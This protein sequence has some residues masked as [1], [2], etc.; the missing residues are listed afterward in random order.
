MPPID[1]ERVRDRRDELGLRNGQ[2]ASELDL[3]TPSVENIMCGNA[4][5]SMRVVHGL[6]RL[7]GLTVAVI[8]GGA[9]TPQGDPSEPPIQP[10]KGPA[11]P[12]SRQDTEDK[13]T[14]RSGPRRA[15]ERAA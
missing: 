11:G 15:A 9:R 1:Y 6:S 13:K 2:I 8:V 14:R 3:E 5:P 7:L 12:P 4:D 10:T